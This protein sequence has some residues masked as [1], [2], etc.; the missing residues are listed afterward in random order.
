M[1]LFPLACASWARDPELLATELEGEG[2]DPLAVDES[3]ALAAAALAAVRLGAMVEEAKAAAVEDAL[4]TAARRKKLQDVQGRTGN[5]CAGVRAIPL[6]WRW[7]QH[8]VRVPASLNSVP[9]HWVGFDG[10]SIEGPMGYAAPSGN[11][12]KLMQARQSTRNG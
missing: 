8:P 2:V 10:G 9:Y 12:F 1:A 5:C 7:A 6:V 4:A 3:A 11:R